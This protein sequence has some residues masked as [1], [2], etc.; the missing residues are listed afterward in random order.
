MVSF[1]VRFINL[2]LLGSLVSAPT[3]GGAEALTPSV[4]STP[5]VIAH[6]GA[7]GYVP[8]HTLA[9]YSIAILQ[10]ADFIEPDLVMTRDGALIARHDNV[11]DLTTD[12]ASHP[13]FADRKTTKTV[14]G[15]PITGWFSEDFTLAEIRQLRAIERIP[16]VRPS[17]TKF[18]GMFTIPT[19][20]EIIDLAKAMEA[21]TGRP[22]GIY[23]ETK[24]PT[25]FADQGLAMEEKLVDIL[26]RNGYRGKAAPIYI[27]S[28]EVSNLQKLNQ[29]T[30]L[31]LIQLLWID[32][33]P[34]DVAKNGGDL[35][36]EDMATAKG[37]QQIAQYADGVGPEKYHF[38]LPRNGDDTLDPKQATDFVRQ[39]HAAGLMVHPF[40]FRA[41]NQ[42][43]PGNLQSDS[44]ATSRF[45]DAAQEVR[46]FLELGID[47]FFIDQ[48]DLGVK[49]RDNWQTTRP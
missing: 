28:F 9:A 29:L 21:T 1:L 15:Q 10:G 25:H 7:S 6:R 14:D 36:Y 24:H 32:G 13:E 47:G 23:P 12:V 41:E 20:Q 18:N 43:L 33:Q 44:Q 8:E 16:D 17:N 2:A 11:L 31:P 42:F 45:G 35:T 27:Q 4:K 48:P 39:A 5:I 37:L 19:L 30:D 3:K 49:A 34:F 40:T 22:I 46:I 38:I 26:H